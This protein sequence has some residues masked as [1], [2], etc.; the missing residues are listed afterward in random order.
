MKNLFGKVVDKL[1]RS[2]LDDKAANQFVKNQSGIYALSYLNQRTGKFEL[3]YVG[4]AVGNLHRRIKAHLKDSHKNKWTHFSA[5]LV[6]QKEYVDRLEAFAI[7]RGLPPGDKAQPIKG[8]N[9]NTEIIQ[10]KKEVLKRVY[11][12]H[13][14][15]STASKKIDKKHPNLNGYFNSDRPLMAKYNNKEYKAILLTNGLVKYKGE[16][17]TIN[18]AALKI[19]HYTRINAWT[20]WEVKDDKGN[21]ILLNKLS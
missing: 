13:H 17:L 6:L 1:C 15:T 16:L 4:K 18:Q 7:S 3:H 11:S 10:A 20:F 19:V 5:Y 21:W 8:E 9:A 14:R 2:L 12:G